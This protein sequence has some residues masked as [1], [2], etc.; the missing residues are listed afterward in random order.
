MS[1]EVTEPEQGSRLQEEP[2]G[3]KPKII[4]QRPSI[5][6]TSQMAVFFPINAVYLPKNQDQL[7]EEPLFVS[8]SL[9]VVH[10]EGVEAQKDFSHHQNYCM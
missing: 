4:R 8:H 2:G 7:V 1:K 3:R 6:G 5:S 10:S 9:F